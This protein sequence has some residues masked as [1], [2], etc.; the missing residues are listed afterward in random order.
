MK[1]EKETFFLQE[2]GIEKD[3]CKGKKWEILTHFFN[4]LPL[5][6]SLSILM[7]H[8][9]RPL[10]H[11]FWGLRSHTQREMW[12]EKKNFRE[13]AVRVLTNQE[14]EGGGRRKGEG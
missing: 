3:F 7:M 6:L 9:L 5:S 14:K 11:Y 1:E 13:T 10:S 12:K 4:P 8:T 2:R